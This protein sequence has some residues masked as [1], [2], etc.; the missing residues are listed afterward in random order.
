MKSLVGSGL[1]G[2]HRATRAGRRPLPGIYHVMSP[3]EMTMDLDEIWPAWIRQ[4]T[5]GWS[6][7]STT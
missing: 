7:R 3:F 5:P 4:A 2:W 1:I 6:S